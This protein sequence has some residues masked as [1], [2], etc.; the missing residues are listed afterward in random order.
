MFKGANVPGLIIGV[1][2]VLLAPALLPAVGR[3]VRPVAK[4]AIRTGISIY[5]EASTQ[6]ASA[7]GPLIEEVHGEMAASKRAGH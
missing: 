6:I 5:R 7:T 1:G 2:A 3:A 4:A